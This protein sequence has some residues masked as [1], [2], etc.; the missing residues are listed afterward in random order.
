[1]ITRAPKLGIATTLAHH[2]RYGQLL[3]DPQIMGAT[4]A[5]PNK[6]LF[7]VTPKDA[8]ELAGEFAD[9]PPVII[10]REP[11]LVLSHEPVADLLRREHKNAN[12]EKFVVD[13]LMPWNENIK[14][15]KDAIE[16][17]RAIRTARLDEAATYRDDANFY[18]MEA[19]IG[20]M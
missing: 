12:I 7:Q 19:R 20:G 11:E 6:V 4:A 10:K 17:K 9:K 2:E 13:L 1:M 3:D 15:L 8:Q 18:D 16:G 14:R 5:I